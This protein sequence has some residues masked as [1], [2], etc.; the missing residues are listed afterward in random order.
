MQKQYS[1]KDKVGEMQITYVYVQSDTGTWEHWR[2][3]IERGKTEGP[4]G[5][6]ANLIKQE[7]KSS[8]LEQKMRPQNL[9]LV[10]TRR[11]T[12]SLQPRCS[13][14]NRTQGSATVLLE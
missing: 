13:L 1:W 9:L 6:V 3:V 4:T 11:R 2:R 12:S 10:A 8:S 7:I 5:E 14:Q